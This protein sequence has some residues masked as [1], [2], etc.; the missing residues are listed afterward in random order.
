MIET[1]GLTYLHLAVN[2]LQRSLRFYTE[3]FGMEVRFWDGP[4]MVFLNTP[5]AR[6]IITLR[7][8][9]EDEN[10]GASGVG[11]FGF[12][13]KSK[14]DLDRAVQTVISSGGSLIN[15]GEHQ[16]GQP[17]AYVAY[18]DGHVIEL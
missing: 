1:Y 16:L 3:V 15:R 18:P 14:E 2:D 9:S 7:Q 8:A 10:M 4:T 13:L 5:G 6:D 12:R 17:F 11:H